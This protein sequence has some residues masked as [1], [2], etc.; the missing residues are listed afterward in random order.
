MCTRG[1][2]AAL[3][4]VVALV[5]SAPAHADTGPLRFERA[6]SLGS[7]AHDIVLDL[8]GGLAYVAVDRGLVILGLANPAAPMEV[9]SVETGAPAITQGVAVSGNYAYLASREAG[10]HVVNVSNPKAPSLLGSKRFSTPV[11]DVAVKGHPTNDMIAY[12][13]A[14]TFGGE[15]YVLEHHA[16]QPAN[17]KQVKVIGLV[18][19]RNPKQDALAFKKLNAHVTGGSAK[20]TNLFITERRRPDGSVQDLLFTTD[21]NYGHAYCYDISNPANPTFMGAHGVPFVLQVE[22]DPDKDTVYMLVAGSKLSGI[23][24]VPLSHFSSAKAT[25]YLTCPECRFIK[26]KGNID[27]GGM[28]LSTGGNR[29][30]YGGGFQRELHVVNVEDPDEMRALAFADVGN[31]GLGLAEIMGFASHGNLLYVAAGAQGFQVYSFPGAD[32]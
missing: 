4:V 12:V 6:V 32:N 29:L 17:L 2:V 16:S 31:H 30:F 14:V 9:G 22:A 15:M 11:W 7:R 19:W 13:Y 8:D 20:A 21:W 5:W 1:L 3:A 25:Y 18:A 10:V 27:M 28:A 26:S 24:T 23:H